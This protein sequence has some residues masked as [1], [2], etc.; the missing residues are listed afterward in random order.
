MTRVLR[1]HVFLAIAGLVTLP[2][3]AG[4][5]QGQAPDSVASVGFLAGGTWLG[6]GRWPD[7]SQLKVEVRYFWGPTRQV[8]H[9]ESFDLA[10]GHRALLYEGM[11]VFDPA[12]GRLAQWNVKPDG[13]VNVSEIVHPDSTGFEVVGAHTRSTIRRI[14]SDRFR[15]ELR[16][17]KDG[18]W[19]TI[20]EA[21]YGRQVGTEERER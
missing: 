19:N 2:A 11:I 5:L 21:T 4:R 12:R 8:L 15:W 3:A 10:E 13:E 6:E 1:P 9:F 18:G 7:G 17:P 20:L 14:G 16:V